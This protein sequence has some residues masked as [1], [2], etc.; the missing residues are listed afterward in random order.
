[1]QSPVPH[2]LDNRMTLKF[3]A[4]KEEHQGDQNGH[5]LLEKM[6]HLTPTG[7]NRGQNDR[8][9]Q[10]HQERVKALHGTHMSVFVMNMQLA[11]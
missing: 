3:G 1:M 10:G 4:L 6:L 11:L 7:Q 8:A 5:D 2:A 9:D